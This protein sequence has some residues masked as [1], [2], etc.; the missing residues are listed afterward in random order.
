MTLAHARVAQGAALALLATLLSV[1]ASPPTA[2]QAA[3][4]TGVAAEQEPAAETEA[5]A[6][7][8]AELCAK[9]VE[10]LA[11]ANETTKVLAQPDGNFSLE[12]YLEPQRVERGDRWVPLDTTL[13]RSADGR[14]RPRAA[15]DVSFSAGGTG[16]LATYREGGAD[17]TLTWPE[18]LPAGVVSE[19][20]VTYPEV[21]PGA[22]L[23]VRAVPGGFSHVLV[24]KNAEAAANPEVRESAY[25]IGGSATVTETNDE[26]VIKGP[27][28]VVAGAP[29]A[30]AWDSTRQVR[31]PQAAGLRQL[32]A[33]GI[34][35]LRVA[36]ASTAEAPSDLARRSDLDV[37]IADR[38]LTV[39]V[40]EE[41]LS[42]QSTFPVYID[43][44]YSKY[45][46]KWIPV[47][48]SRPDTKWV[49]GNSWPREVIRIGSNFESTGD[50][51]R[52]HMQ[53]D[54]SVLKGKR[55]IKT[56]SVDA[57]LTHSAWCA[58]ESL[59][60]W[61][62]NAI[63]GNTPTWN[64]MKGKWLHGKAIHTKTVKVNSACSGQKP[65]WVK[66]NASGVKSHVQRHADENYSSIT[67]GL[68]VP[69]ESGGH[70]VKAER[71]KV[72]L[73][74]E[75]QSK[76]TSPT[77]VRTA[78]GGNCA[79]TPGPWINDSTPALYAKATDA[80]NSVRLVFDV[81]GP[82]VPTDFTSA[83]VG[84][85][86]E[87]AWTTPV[88][89]DGNYNWKVYA[90]D[91]TDKTG[92]SKTCYFRQDHTPP[93]LPVIGRK[94]GTP[95]PELGKPVTLVF[96]STDALS[97]VQR[98]DY[99][100]G[101]DAKSE[102]KVATSSKAEVTFTADS[103]RTQIYV[104]ARDNAGNYSSRAIY[105]IFTGRVTPIEP[106]AVWRMTSNLR[107]DS[108]TTDDEGN[109]SESATEKDLR[110]TVAGAPTYSADRLNR[111]G[112]ALNLTGTGCATTGPV[113]R[114]D[115]PFTAA[116]WVKL[117]SKAAGSNRTVLAIAGT[118]A[119]AFVLSYHQAT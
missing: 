12:S 33:G 111:G 17:F 99:G 39:K 117:T 108:G 13:E 73:V 46:A 110:W 48:D 49:S 107:D 75:Y 84:S 67:F 25:A 31:E 43:P 36:E 57:Y 26:I 95:A 72:K 23:V 92:W 1:A 45:Y 66:F 24:V 9:P 61:Q 96:S 68:R 11:E 35:P 54:V 114:S 3:C 76:P 91:G 65:A 100:I 29:P 41:L 69:T 113:V 79:A 106:M 50:L 105:N 109:V 71:G 15:A 44:V 30:I 42:E 98:F 6:Q 77:P 94:S 89:K 7:R 62:T 81:N 34:A 37:R 119:P 59:A 93:T 104:W 115:A 38:K 14:F 74:V 118:N 63:D 80:D 16:P 5:A 116:A 27:A 51:W 83:A 52:A 19:D 90:T 58:G 53:F 32:D 60:L 21:H 78:P 56:P 70:W 64:G 4:P 28:G 112:T 55:V 87:A 88:L 103:G 102:N 40:G 22:D 101:V 47:N 10:V 86:K 20:A 82:T 97:G 2:A 18:A 85:G 8:L